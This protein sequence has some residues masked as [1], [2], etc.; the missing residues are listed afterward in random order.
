VPARD[1]D[2]MSLDRE[3][4]RHARLAGAVQAIEDLT[5]LDP[6]RARDLETVWPELFAKLQ[7]AFRINRG[8]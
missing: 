6:E 5:M 8:D 1:A 3:R 7:A 2:Q 4:L